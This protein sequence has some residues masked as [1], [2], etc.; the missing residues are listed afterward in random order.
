MHT[1]FG[2]TRGVLPAA[3]LRRVRT[4]LVVLAVLATAG[5]GL[6]GD[7]GPQDTVTAFATCSA[8][9]SRLIVNFQ[10]PAISTKLGHLAA[11]LSAVLVLADDVGRGA[12]CVRRGGGADHVVPRRLDFVHSVVTSPRWATASAPATISANSRVSS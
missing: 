3:A 1:R 10:T 11:Q 4:A 2:N 9:N 8:P 5:C 12:I 6:F 7:S